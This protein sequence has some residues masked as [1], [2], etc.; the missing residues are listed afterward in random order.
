MW[1]GAGSG[2]HAPIRSGTAGER[3]E[4]RSGPLL[5]RINGFAGAATVADPSLFGCFF[6]EN[7]VQIHALERRRGNAFPVVSGARFGS[8]NGAIIEPKTDQVASCARARSSFTDCASFLLIFLVKEH[9][10]TAVF[11]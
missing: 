11:L 6:M 10:K 3:S 4:P 7:R 8:Q 9:R 2:A 1:R 5:S